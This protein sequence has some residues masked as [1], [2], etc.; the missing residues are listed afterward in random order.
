[1]NTGV[2]SSGRNLSAGE[3][4][5]DF[6]GFSVNYR[7]W[8]LAASASLSENYDRP[9][10]YVEQAE[11]GF[12]T[13]TFSSRQD[14][15]LRLFNIS[16]ARQ[17]GGAFRA[18]LGFNFVHGSLQRKIRESFI[19]L[20]ENTVITDEKSQD[21][22]GFYLNGGIVAG[23]T[24]NL[25]VALVFRAP[26]FRRAQSAS[27][28]KYSAPLGDTEITIAAESAD[29]VRQP[30]IIGLG[31]AYRLSPR[32]RVLSEATF[33]NW[34]EYEVEYFGEPAER[35][36]RGTLKLSLGAEHDWNL[37]LSGKDATV[38]LRAGVN[39]DPQPMPEPRSAYLNVTL[40]SGLRWR[41]LALDLGGMLG[42]E[43]GSGNNLQVK[44]LVL[45][46]SVR[47]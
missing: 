28:L 25:D 16:L 24:S 22:S 40:G 39:H 4:A 41:Q 30:W 15:L 38:I 47:L 2:L 8:V 21:F 6:V 29:R 7:G 31:G 23:L 5:L 34:S 26:Y 17:I 42:R 20:G 18:G 32:L 11:A 45:T 13:Y 1:V 27:T 33:F 36:F 35:N 14:G 10:A 19:G 12:L 9:W 37:R 3:T 46:A 44:R 43:S